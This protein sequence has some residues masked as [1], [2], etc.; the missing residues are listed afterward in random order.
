[1]EYVQVGSLRIS[2]IGLGTWQFGS[3]EWGYGRQYAEKEA[4]AIVK[5][6][7]E[8]GINLFDTAE[9]YGLGRSERILGEA[10][11]EAGGE[12]AVV[13]TKLLPV[14]PLPGYVRSRAEKSLMRLGKDR[15]HLYQV[16]W[17][18]PVFPIPLLMREMRELKEDGKVAE[19]GVSNFSLSAWKKAEEALG[20]KVISNQVPYSLVQREAEAELIPHA[21]KGGRVIIAYSPLCQGF[22]SA[23]YSPNY[24][25]RGAVRRGNPLFLSENLKRAAGLFSA[26]REIARAH[27]ASPAQIALAWV[28]RKPCV[29]A[30]PGAAS[31]AQLEANAEAAKI[32]LSPEEV[33]WLEQ[34]AQAF[35]PLRGPR[36][37]LPLARSALRPRT[38]GEGRGP[39]G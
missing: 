21:E 31:V 10:L 6:A 23:R 12:G 5:R 11:R 13:A 4:R 39:A 36:A 18:N 28:I 19:V 27:S 14:F 17:P 9:V 30:I 25:P 37:L 1:M 33:S 2:R 3:R 35:R 34:E 22:L 26:L 16:H 15:I 24:P 20:E 7:L 29:V 8:L 38:S 32:R